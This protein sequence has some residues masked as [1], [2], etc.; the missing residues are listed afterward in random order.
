MR[1][2]FTLFAFFLVSYLA[3][4]Q[5]LEK[6]IESF[7]Q[8]FQIA[9]FIDS[10]EVIN[11]GITPVEKRSKMGNVTVIVD[12]DSFIPQRKDTVLYQYID[13]LSA[14]LSKYPE[15]YLQ[16]IGLEAIAL[17]AELFVGKTKRGG[18]P[19]HQTNT[20]LYEASYAMLYDEA[21]MANVIH[22]EL[23]HF[24]EQTLEK[25]ERYF[26]KWEKINPPKFKY[27]YGGIMQ[28]DPRYQNVDFASYNHPKEGFVS[29][30]AMTGAEED[31]AMIVSLIMNERERAELLKW[32]PSDQLLQKKVKLAIEMLNTLSGTSENYW[33]EVMTGYQ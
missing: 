2:V 33:T 27:G 29:N 11:H 14:E 9:L 10:M 28:Y 31:R 23:H 3:S 32:L 13:F 4:S 26:K 7:E 16:N 6:T 24:A 17:G 18:I 15:K 12:G 19:N 22:H 21:Y 25:R 1:F 30:Y 8:H 5:Y 20:I